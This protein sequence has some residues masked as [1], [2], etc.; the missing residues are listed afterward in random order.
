MNKV[1]VKLIDRLTPG[2]EKVAMLSSERLDRRLTLKE[3]LSIRLHFV[4]CYFCKRYHDQLDSIHGEMSQRSEKF[5]QQCG[6]CLGDEEKAR[7]KEVCR[8]GLQ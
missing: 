2:C 7:L 8:K 4:I 5:G 6:K 1:L 3:R